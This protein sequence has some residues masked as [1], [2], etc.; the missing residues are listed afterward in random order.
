VVFPAIGKQT[1]ASKEA[2]YKF[3]SRSDHGA[4]FLVCRKSSSIRWL[5]SSE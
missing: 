4:G 2:S 3:S 5:Y 1:L